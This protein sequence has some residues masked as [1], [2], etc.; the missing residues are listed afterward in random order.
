MPSRLAMS[1][2][3]TRALQ[4]ADLDTDAAFALS[5][6]VNAMM[7]T[8]YGDLYGV[9]AAA[10]YRYF[11]YS[12]TFTTTG[13][14]TLA[15]PVDHL[16]TVDTLERVLPGGRLRRLQQI[17][18]QER[19]MWAGRTGHARKWEM[20][21]DTIYLYPTPPTGDQYILRYVAQPPDLTLYA[22]SSVIDLVTPDGQGFM[23]WGCVVRFL[24]RIRSDVTLAI[25][26]REQARARFMDWARRRAFNEP[27]RMI[28][29]DQD[30]GPYCD[31]DW[32]FDR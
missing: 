19:A 5:P 2:V 22:D 1:D 18:P 4:Q 24:A 14:N 6:L 10:G 25:Q 29:D 27:Q 13:T 32:W 31:G 12:T 15:E 16:S 23:I 3:R 20:V 11:E 17:M 26:E 30:D 7:S 28:V 8:Q 21:D 9:A